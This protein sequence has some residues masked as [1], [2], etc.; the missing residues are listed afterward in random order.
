MLVQ[1]HNR[2]YNP[3]QDDARDIDL[4]KLI[5]KNG[6]ERI[7]FKCACWLPCRHTYVYA[8]VQSAISKCLIKQEYYVARGIRNIAL[9][10]VRVFRKLSTDVAHAMPIDNLIIN[11]ILSKSMWISPTGVRVTSGF[12]VSRAQLLRAFDMIAIYRSCYSARGI[13]NM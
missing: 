11:R 3:R 2:T 12:N 13:N 9:H 4:R 10:I 1:L 5:H 6:T 8:L 7:A